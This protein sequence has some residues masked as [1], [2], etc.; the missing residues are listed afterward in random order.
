MVVIFSRKYKI[1]LRYINIIYFI[2]V[3]YTHVRVREQTYMI[4]SKNNITYLICM[5]IEN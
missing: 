4:Y 5:L 3:L 2:K 1:F